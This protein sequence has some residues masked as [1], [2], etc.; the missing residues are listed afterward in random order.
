MSAPNGHAEGNV[1]T[2]S[3][4]NSHAEGSSTTASG[5]NSHAEGNDTTASGNNSHAEG[6]SNTASGVNSHAEGAGNTASAEN[7]H[8]EGSGTQASGYQAHAEGSG[9]VASGSRSHAE[10][11]GTVAYGMSQHAQ[12]RYN[13]SHDPVNAEIEAWEAGKSYDYGD[14]ICTNG[15]VYGCLEP[16][17]DDVF[18]ARKWSTMGNSKVAFMIGNGVSN[19]IRHTGFAI[20]WDGSVMARKKIVIGNTTITESQLQALPA[21][22]N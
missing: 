13:Q 3:G 4:T 19:D 8:A 2:A 22:L 15:T 16:N 20:L 14:V 21:L 5:L 10:G 18:T 9:S 11:T 12:G 6:S 17:S 1:T 7:S